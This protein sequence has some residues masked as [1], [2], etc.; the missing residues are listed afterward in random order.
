MTPKSADSKVKKEIEM[1]FHC[2]NCLGKVPENEKYRP[3]LEVGWTEKGLQVWCKL[4]NSNI[5]HLD[6]KGEKIDVA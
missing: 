1:F 3:Y 6:F 2:A 5:I 4:C